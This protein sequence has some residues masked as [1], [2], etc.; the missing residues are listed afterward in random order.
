MTS[1][2]RRCGFTRRRMLMQAAVASGVSALFKMTEGSASAQEAGA[3]R[4]GP[5][6][7]GMGAGGRG[8]QTVHYGPMNG[9]VNKLS[10]P[11]D[12]KVTDMRVVTVASNYDYNIIRRTR[13]RAS[14]GWERSATRVARTPCWSSSPT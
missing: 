2:E 12:L 13:T 1:R 6:G 14:T 5:G 9:P 10:A 8:G 7:L 3:G 11:S 4:G